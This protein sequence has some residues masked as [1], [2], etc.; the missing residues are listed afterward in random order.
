MHFEL[1]NCFI[2]GTISLQEKR[3]G[4]DC[5]PTKQNTLIHFTFLNLYYF[6]LRLK[7]ETPTLENWWRMSG[8]LHKKLLTESPILKQRS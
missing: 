7:E 4:Q 6:F 2:Y 5:T 8:L 3:V 1:A